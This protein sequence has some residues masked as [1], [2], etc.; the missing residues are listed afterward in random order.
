VVLAA[1]TLLSCGGA[2]AQA[3]GAPTT[4]LL[5]VEGRDHEVWLT[6]GSPVQTTPALFEVPCGTVAVQFRK[7]LCAGR[8]EVEASLEQ[9]GLVDVSKAPL[10]T[11]VVAITSPVPVRVADFFTGTGRHVKGDPGRGAEPHRRSVD[12]A[13]LH[14]AEWDAVCHAYSV[15]PFLGDEVLPAPMQEFDARSGQTVELQA[16]PRTGPTFTVVPFS[17]GRIIL[18]S[19][20]P[21]VGWAVEMTPGEP[22]TLPMEVT[23]TRLSNCRN[24]REGGWPGPTLDDLAPGDRVGIYQGRKCHIQRWDLPPDT[25]L[26][27]VGWQAV[28]GTKGESW[29]LTLMTDEGHQR[30]QE[31]TLRIGDTTLDQGWQTQTHAHWDKMERDWLLR[32]AHA[33][34][35]GDQVLR[36]QL[37]VCHSD[38]RVTLADGEFQTVELDDP[39]ETTG[40]IEVVP[41]PD[42][43]Q[44]WVRGGDTCRSWTA[45]DLD[46]ARTSGG[47]LTTD[48]PCGAAYVTAAYTGSRAVHQD[49]CEPVR[50]RPQGLVDLGHP[51]HT[52]TRVVKADVTRLDVTTGETHRVATRPSAEVTLLPPQG[53]AD[54][55][56]SIG[57]IPVKPGTTVVTPAGPTAVGAV[58]EDWDLRCTETLDVAPGARLR[59]VAC[60]DWEPAVK[61][62]R[63]T[64]PDL[65]LDGPEIAARVPSAGRVRLLV[66]VSSIGETVAARAEPPVHPDLDAVC[67]EAAMALSWTPGTRLGQVVDVADVPL[68]CHVGQRVMTLPD[69]WSQTRRRNVLS[70]QKLGPGPLCLVRLELVEGRARSTTGLLIREMEV[71]WSST[72]KAGIACYA[73]IE[74]SIWYSRPLLD[75][76]RQTQ[77]LVVFQIP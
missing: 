17:A 40:T 32:R 24:K 59:H 35:A 54:A 64:T 21:G 73:A 74:G 23:G 61:N 56:L 71:T 26:V 70:D 30:V 19:D 9:T 4:C 28:Y 77:A 75:G 15:R 11:A 37:G 8:V 39:R 52:G 68:W 25:A 33:L 45:A 31:G 66:D 50:G 14:R 62:P 34:P 48:V 20:Q 41:H 29:S 67:A 42:A 63:P 38:T 18:T 3:P 58:H 69:G 46:L 47:P 1:L 49:P 43:Q 55:R 5:R 10:E 72:L 65:R 53:L 7:D 60:A 44:V 36:A 16:T 51:T 57:G 22:L 27:T 6:E 13:G 76:E 12:A 2:Q